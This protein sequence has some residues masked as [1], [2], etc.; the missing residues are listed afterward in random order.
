MGRGISSAYKNMGIFL[1]RGELVW[2]N[3][4]PKTNTREMEIMRVSGAKGS[5][6]TFP[7]WCIV[8][9]AN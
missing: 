2:G 8:T 6:L 1:K 9:C 5:M 7:L 3:L 4:P